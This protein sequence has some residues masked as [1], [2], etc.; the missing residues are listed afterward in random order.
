[1]IIKKIS[2]KQKIVLSTGGILLALCLVSF[3]IIMPTVKYIK[4]LK[5]NIEITENEIEKSYQ[6][7][8]SLKNSINKLGEIKSEV[9]P[10]Y[11]LTLDEGDELSVIKVL[12][13]LAS[14]NN[15]LQ[16]LDVNFND[17]KTLSKDNL[18]NKPH[19]VFK[20]K[21]VGKYVDILNYLDD[22]EELPYY[23]LIDQISFGLE[24]NQSNGTVFANLSL[25]L[26][27]TVNFYNSFE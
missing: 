27:S 22:L 6:K 19:Y 8:N 5:R 15:V 11:F 21:L 25:I 23:F 14:Q 18:Y 10:F 7:I 12:E 20:L 3:G 9:E 16:T 26:N 17:C 2:A 4:G 1:M 13:S 24:K